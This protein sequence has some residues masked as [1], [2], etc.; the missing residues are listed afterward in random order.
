MIE[1]AIKRLSDIA[2]TA[3]NDAHNRQRFIKEASESF[4]YINISVI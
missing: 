2:T 3:Q 1:V 4:T